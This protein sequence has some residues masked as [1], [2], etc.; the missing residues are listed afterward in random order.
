MT[1]SALAVG[2]LVSAIVAAT[3][4]AQP[5]APARDSLRLGALHREAIARDPRGQQLDLLASQAGLR[6][7]SLDAERLPSLTTAALAQYLSDVPSVS[8]PGISQPPHDQYD[9]NVGARQRIFDPSRAPRRELERA[10]LAE[11]QAR[12][13]TALFAL[14]QNVND[15]FFAAL[16]AQAQRSELENGITDLQAQL[17]LAQDRLRL[18]AALPS[19]PTTIEAELVRRRQAI[20]DLDAARDAALAVLGDLTGRTLSAA[21]PLALPESGTDVAQA[22]SR[23]GEVRERPEYEQFARTREVLDRRL[24]TLAA[25][26]RPRIYAFGRTGYGR[27]G[28]N[29]L[30]RELDEYWTAG[31]QVEW[32]PWRWGT[33]QRE[34]EELELQQQVV[35]TE[36]A[37]FTAAVR[38]GVVSELATIDRLERSL[39][40]DEE[41]I[42]LRERVLAEARVRHGEGVMTAAEFVDRETDVLAARLARA[43]RRVELARSRARF[44]TLIGREVR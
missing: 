16:M 36:E 15:A 29:P 18:G 2:L 41:I 12:V 11:S 4:D 17:R 30:A 6:L 9:V 20:A 3:S 10:S 8:L 23:L 32:T 19:E 5:G 34:R 38:R 42:A 25:Q 37:A 22:R 7:R 21:D 14:R 44:L 24:G 13:H 26:D 33:A 40:A 1:R 43:T 39:Q 31:V 28:L 27:P 35:A